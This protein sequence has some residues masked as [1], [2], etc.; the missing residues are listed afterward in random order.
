MA[1][2]SSNSGNVALVIIVLVILH[3]FLMLNF[4]P[5]AEMLDTV[6]AWLKELANR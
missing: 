5:Y 1:K 2:K 3:V 4:E 6:F